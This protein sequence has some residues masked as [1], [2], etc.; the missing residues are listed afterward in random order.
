MADIRLIE[1]GAGI[2]AAQLTN[3]HPASAGCGGWRVLLKCSRALASED[4]IGL[5][6]LH[7]G[8]GYRAGAGRGRASHDRRRQP[9]SIVLALLPADNATDGGIL[10]S[11][12]VGA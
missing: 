12:P 6:A 5:R 1:T 2:F 10:G 7:G 4:F 3:G 11:A 8:R 9:S